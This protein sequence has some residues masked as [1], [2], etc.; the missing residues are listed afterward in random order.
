[1]KS[2]CLPDLPTAAFTS[3]GTPTGCHLQQT[4][5]TST[6]ISEFPME[7]LSDTKP[8]TFLLPHP[9]S[10]SSKEMCH[11]IMETVCIKSFE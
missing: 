5:A 8:I 7:N 6:E 11:I 3:D 9:S 2:A 1:M 4:D 10:P